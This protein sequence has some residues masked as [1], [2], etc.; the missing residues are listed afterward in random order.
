[1]TKKPTVKSMHDYISVNFGQG[2]VFTVSFRGSKGT[3]LP[4]DVFTRLDNFVQAEVKKPEGNYGKAIEAL[5]EQIDT[6]WADWQKPMPPFVAG[7]RVIGPT[8]VQGTVKKKART[9]YEVQFDGDRFVTS[10]SPT[11]IKKIP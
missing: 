7:D 6:L 8:G 1:M 4:S 5:V 11:L 10:I 2:Q 9:N 3:N